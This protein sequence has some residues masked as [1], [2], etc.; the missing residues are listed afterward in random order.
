M[1]RRRQRRLVR[2]LGRLLP[3]GVAGGVLTVSSRT[4]QGLP[5]PPSQGRDMRPVAILGLVA[6]IAI[7]VL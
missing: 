3:A 1:W 7:L 4:A 5:T 2:L 6:A